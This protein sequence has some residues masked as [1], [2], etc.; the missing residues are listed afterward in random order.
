MHYLPQFD[1]LK[2][3]INSIRFVAVKLPQSNSLQGSWDICFHPVK[4]VK[5]RS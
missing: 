1:S 3:V 5:C 2:V 4:F